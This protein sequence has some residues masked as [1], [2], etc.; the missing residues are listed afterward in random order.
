M[1]RFK[2]SAPWPEVKEKM[3]EINISLNDQDLA[4]EPGQ[5]D[6]L[7]ERLQ[8]KIN[9]SKVEIKGIIESMHN[10][11]LAGGTPPATDD[12]QYELERVKFALRP[13]N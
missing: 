8:K 9:K 11:P 5:E 1:E 3:K 13:R 7:L 10:G 12:L 4:Y 2:L 6:A